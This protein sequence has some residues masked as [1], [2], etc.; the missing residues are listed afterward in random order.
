MLELLVLF[1][2]GAPLPLILF[3]GPRLRKKIRKDRGKFHRRR[4]SRR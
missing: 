2:F 1:L 3:L 4:A